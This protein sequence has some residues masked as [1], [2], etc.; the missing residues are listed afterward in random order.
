MTSSANEDD[1]D[2]RRAEIKWTRENKRPHGCGDQAERSD[3]LCHQNLDGTC[4]LPTCAYFGLKE[5]D[6]QMSN[7]RS[8][9]NASDH[10][11]KLLLN[12]RFRI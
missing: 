11:Q 2:W 7:L 6:L 12:P 3:G 4:D 8:A 5:G 10:M 9:A 1:K